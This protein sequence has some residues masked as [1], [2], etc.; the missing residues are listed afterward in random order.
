MLR[1]P[2]F[3][4]TFGLAVNVMLWTVPAYV[5]ASALPHVLFPTNTPSLAEA[6]A[7]A[8]RN[9]GSPPSLPDALLQLVGAESE[10]LQVAG[11]GLNAPSPADLGP[12]ADHAGTRVLNAVAVY[13]QSVSAAMKYVPGQ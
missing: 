8:E 9:A 6:L 13:I 3:M 4:A 10:A 11:L 2:I 5:G 7:S 12:R 1:A